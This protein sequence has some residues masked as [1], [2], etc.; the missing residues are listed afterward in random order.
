MKKI[1]YA[2][3]FVGYATHLAMLFIVGDAYGLATWQFWA[4]FIGILIVRAC[5]AGERY[6]AEDNILDTEPPF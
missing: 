2:F 3:G 1:R 6:F 5:D 4:V